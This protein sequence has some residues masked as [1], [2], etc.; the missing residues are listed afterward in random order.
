MDAVRAPDDRRQLVFLR[1][2]LE[3]GEK[4]VDIRDQD[5]GGAHELHVEAGVE[6]VGRRHAL[7]HEARFRA[8]D[9]RQMRQEGDDVVLDLG[10]DGV[11]ARDIEGRGL[12]LVPDLLGGFFR[13]FAELGHGVG[14]MRLDFEPDAETRLGRPDRSHFG[15]AVARN[16][17]ALLGSGVKPWRNTPDRVRKPFVRALAA[18]WSQP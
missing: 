8:D 9:L 5:I 1:P 17:E 10:L 18:V 7:V 2:A 15:A 13:D 12:A 16:H 4:F 3:R 14:G 11:D 6:H